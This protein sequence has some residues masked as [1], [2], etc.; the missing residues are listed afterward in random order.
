MGAGLV[1][2]EFALVL[3][4]DD[5]YWTKEGTQSVE[6]VLVAFALTLLLLSGFS[7]LGVNGV[8]EDEQESRLSGALT[9]LVNFGCV[10][11]ALLK[12]KTRMAVV[13]V[14]VP[15][16]GIFGAVRLARPRSVW[17]RRVYVRRPRTLARA[18]R[19]AAAHD[20]RWGP[21]RRRVDYAVGGRPSP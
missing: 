15:P 7:P 21:L 8:G 9:A 14:L 5:V 12:G 20:R 10:L 11:I 18:E 1:L 3:H 16:V 6:V 19:R 13:G 2:D 17:A 4:L